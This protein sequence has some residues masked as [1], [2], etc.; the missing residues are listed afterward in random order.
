MTV[1]LYDH[2]QKPVAH[3]HISQ[4]DK[5]EEI[6]LV[7]VFSDK[8]LFND[9]IVPL[10]VFQNWKRSRGLL[11]EEELGQLDIWNLGP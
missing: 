2:H 9:S 10:E 8:A 5:G 7:K 4:N 6:V 3:A 1:K 11:E